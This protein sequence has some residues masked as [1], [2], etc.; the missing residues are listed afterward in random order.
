MENMQNMT[1]NTRI[2]VNSDLL[3]ALKT[4][5]YMIVDDIEMLSDGVKDKL[6]SHI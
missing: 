3:Y 2:T 6:K 1:Q 5:Q 4:V